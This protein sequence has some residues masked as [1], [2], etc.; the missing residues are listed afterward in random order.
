MET[1]RFEPPI[2]LLF[3]FPPG[4]TTSTV[5]RAL[6]S[7]YEEDF[8]EWWTQ[9]TLNS[10]AESISFIVGRYDDAADLGLARTHVQTLINSFPGERYTL[11]KPIPVKIERIGENDWV[12]SFEDANLGMSGESQQEAFQN[13]IADILDT[14]ETFGRE[15]HNL[16]PEPSRQM[17]ILREY[18]APQG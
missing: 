4:T 8:Y 16:G 12:A 11:L 3:S 5:T 17:A 6:K 15:E 10:P 13:L 18:I 7:A 9:P 14:F 2:P 1:V